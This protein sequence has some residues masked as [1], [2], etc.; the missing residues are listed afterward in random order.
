M[1][2]VPVGE[3]RAHIFWSQKWGK[4]NACTATTKI[5]FFF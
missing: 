5:W 3:S 2:F 4:Q 1:F